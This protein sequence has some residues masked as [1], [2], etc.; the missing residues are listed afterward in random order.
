MMS[1]LKMN[2][3]VLPSLCLGACIGATLCSFYIASRSDVCKSDVGCKDIY[4][5][6]GSVAILVAGVLSHV[7][8]KRFQN[9][10]G[11]VRVHQH[12]DEECKNDS[13]V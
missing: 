3:V 7:V 13:I 5:N 2:P 12:Q 11:Y 10:H 1:I 6:I 9:R 8:W 4:I